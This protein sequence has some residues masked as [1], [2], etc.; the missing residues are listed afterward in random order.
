MDLRRRTTDLLLLANSMQVT[1]TSHGECTSALLLDAHLIPRRIETHWQW[2]LMVVILI[3]GLGALAWLLVWLKKRH[4]RKVDERRAQ[5]GGFPTERE[6][7]AGARSATPDLWGPHQACNHPL[8]DY[9][10]LTRH[11]T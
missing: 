11:S 8:V 5:L 7:A 3:L 2:I 4:R 6:K 9:Q 10:K 1:A